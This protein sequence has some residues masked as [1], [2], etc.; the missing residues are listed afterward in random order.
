MTRRLLW[1]PRYR[2]STP[3]SRASATRP[4]RA[5]SRMP[6]HATGSSVSDVL[7]ARAA[8]GRAW[9]G[10]LEGSQHARCKLQMHSQE[11]P[12]HSGSSQ[13][14]HHMRC[15]VCTVDCIQGFDPA[16]CMSAV[17]GHAVRVSAP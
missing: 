10:V 11:T 12:Q 17:T 14:P 13:L 5:T 16:D 3:E 2:L 15:C 6:A 1:R 4:V 8:D 7:N 9:P